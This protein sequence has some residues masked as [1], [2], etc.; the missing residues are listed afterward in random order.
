MAELTEGRRGELRA[1]IEDAARRFAEDPST[2][3]E[4]ST[5]M[6]GGY[7][8]GLDRQDVIGRSGLSQH[9]AERVLDG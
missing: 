9:D 7:F 6:R 1:L 3:P 4:L 5:A 2:R 8:A